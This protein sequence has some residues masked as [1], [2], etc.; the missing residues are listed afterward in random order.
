MQKTIPIL[1]IGLLSLSGAFG[2]TVTSSANGNAASAST[3]TNSTLP[4]AYDTV[5]IK[6]TVT[7]SNALTI[8][9]IQARANNAKT[10]VT[11]GANLVFTGSTANNQGF[12]QVGYNNYSVPIAVSMAIEGGNVAIKNNG[13]IGLGNL[14]VAVGANNG[15]IYG[16][17]SATLTISGGTTLVEGGVVLAQAS[18]NCVANGTLSMTGGTLYVM[19]ARSDAGV[20]IRL[21][22]NSGGTYSAT[23]NWTGGNLAVARQ[24]ESLTNTGSGNLIFG[25]YNSTTGV[26][27]AAGGTTR[28]N[29]G[30][31]SSA[32]TYTQGASASATFNLQSASVY[33]QMLWYDATN[34]V[35]GNTVA[36]ANGTTIYLN[37]VDGATYS[38]GDTINI[39]ITDT[40]TIDGEAAS[41][42]NLSK[43]HFAGNG[44]DN[45][46][47]S[48]SSVSGRTALTLTYVP[49][50]AT[51]ASLL[52]LIALLLV[53]RRRRA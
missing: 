21:T 17:T 24:V 51:A 4:S 52:G 44:A 16:T 37:L 26:F 7:F 53:A 41:A 29:G 22:N 2:A 49:E 31:F 34:A 40:L 19:S 39:L 25:N 28:L 12:L 47:A 11:T 43:L 50:P 33:D 8:R 6:N 15:S 27:A 9:S 20:G 14:V 18:A 3:W 35:A 46:E 5:V 32:L 13:T 45:F 30:Y 36:L 42:S 23:F 1:S 48:L 38:L 10:I